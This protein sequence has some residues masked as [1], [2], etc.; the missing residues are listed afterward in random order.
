MTSN[1]ETLNYAELT[2]DER[3]GIYMDAL[4]RRELGR[5]QPSDDAALDILPLSFATPEEQGILTDY[6]RQRDALNYYLSQV[7]RVHARLLHA[8]S[9]LCSSLLLY[10]SALEVEAALTLACSD[11]KQKQTILST[12][13]ENGRVFPQLG[14]LK[15]DGSLALAT[16]KGRG[17]FP[18]GN[19]IRHLQS[20]VK[21]LQSGI[22]AALQAGKDYLRHRRLKTEFYRDELKDYERRLSKDP[23]LFDGFGRTT[24]K[25]EIELYAR[26]QQALGQPPFPAYVDAT[27]DQEY[28][29]YILDVCLKN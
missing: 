7:D 8:Q 27:V 19:A 21:S 4:T 23:S 6:C 20:E 10:A 28:Y 12:L 14:E 22:K 17:G 3:A 13:W 5:S 11:E 2:A 16:V 26:L 18:I 9:R 15:A 24:R 1:R 29:D 25:D